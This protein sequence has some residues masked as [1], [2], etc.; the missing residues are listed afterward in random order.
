M[1]LSMI[2]P[3]PKGFDLR[4]FKYGKCEHVHK[5]SAAR[6]P[7]KSRLSGSLDARDLKAPK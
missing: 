6:N 5:Q 7:M 4:T 2:A 3:E 1:S